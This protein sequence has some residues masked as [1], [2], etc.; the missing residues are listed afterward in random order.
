L[1]LYM[2]SNLAHRQEFPNRHCQI[3]GFDSKWIMA[4][5]ALHADQA[6]FSE[7]L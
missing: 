5:G 3:C 6:Q 7:F 1:S 2:A 4:W